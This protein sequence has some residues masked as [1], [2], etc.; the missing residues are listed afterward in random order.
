MKAQYAVSSG[1]IAPTLFQPKTDYLT[2][3]ICGHRASIPRWLAS[4]PR[5]G[6]TPMRFKWTSNS[7][8]DGLSRDPGRNVY[9]GA[10]GATL[11]HTGLTAA[12]HF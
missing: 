8:M 2:T 5:D 9:S 3:H 10:R 6:K 1:S 7:E 11:T 12:R 4:C